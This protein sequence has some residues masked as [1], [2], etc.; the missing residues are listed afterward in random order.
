MCE[1]L[2]LI[3][4]TTKTKQKITPSTTTQKQ[5]KSSYPGYR[6]SCRKG[7]SPL[8]RAVSSEIRG[9][10]GLAGQVWPAYQGRQS[11]RHPL[12]QG[13]VQGRGDTQAKDC[14][15]PGKSR[16][17]RDEGAQATYC[18]ATYCWRRS[19]RQLSQPAL[20]A[21]LP[22]L[23]PSGDRSGSPTYDLEKG[24]RF[25]TFLLFSDRPASREGV[26]WPNSTHLW[27]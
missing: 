15:W 6:K 7:V 2:G 4:S 16:Q 8:T 11:S 18:S 1:A 19:A 27:P 20:P 13:E 3:L 14:M 5:T 10:E 25:C 23:L 24:R 21:S 26:F 9:P 22:S 17:T 12:A